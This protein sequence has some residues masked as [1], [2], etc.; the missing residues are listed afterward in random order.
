MNALGLVWPKGN[1]SQLWAAGAAWIAF[2]V[3]V[4]DAKESA[5]AGA[6]QVWQVNRGVPI[7]NF[8][9]WWSWRRGPS[10]NL[11]GTAI[12]ADAIGASLQGMSVQVALLKAAFLA[13]LVA[14][15]AA[16]AA[17]GIAI[18][19]T[20]GLAAAGA[21]AGG[22]LVI[23]YFRRRMVLALNM[24]LAAITAQLVGVLLRQ[25]AETLQPAPPETMP[26]RDRQRDPQEDP[27]PPLPFPFPLPDS[28]PRPDR[29]QRCS[30][31]PG[32][33]QPTINGIPPGSEDRRVS[34]GGLQSISRRVLPDGSREVVIEGVV[35]DPIPRAGLENGLRPL[36]ESIGIPS[37][38]YH[39]AHTWGAGLGSEAAA[40]IYLAPSQA[41]L[42]YHA[43]VENWLRG[44]HESVGTQ[45]WV[46]LRTV[47]T[48]HPTGAW[49]N[50][51]A[52]L[53]ASTTY[54]ATACYPGGRIV[55]YPAVSV[56]IDPPSNRNGTFQP[57]RVWTEVN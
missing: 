9:Q 22:G 28:Q 44:V 14:L 46:E 37:G 7:S 3:A 17:I 1:A 11:A 12:A 32:W 55:T 5:Q 45:G 43:G 19:G 2:A 54:E 6:A 56:N 15:A 48:T 39:L 18:F 52:N 10:A 21:A 26:R 35:R 33:T 23:G 38:Q 8:Q 36:A 51:G 30:V 50:A 57:G 42:V 13:N 29:R 24:A 53:M 31:Q 49:Q 34:G 4:R 40:G 20:G 47:T 27:R 41:N 16:F 25:A